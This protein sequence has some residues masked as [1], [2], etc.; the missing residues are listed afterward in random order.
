MSIRRPLVQVLSRNFLAV[1]VALFASALAWVYGGTRGEYLPTFV[2]WLTVFTAELMLC[3]P[4]QHEGETS[5]EARLRVWKRIKT[6][7]VVWCVLAFFAILVI[8]FVNVGLCPICDYPKILAGAKADP[9]A[10]FLPT[11]VNTV[12]HLNVALWFFAAL[13]MLLAVKHSLTKAGKRLTLEIIVWN[14]VLLALF[15]FLQQATEAEGPLWQ[16]FNNVIKGGDFFSTFGYPNMAGDYFTTLFA[17]AIGLW[18]EK[19]DPVVHE[20][21]QRRIKHKAV[22]ISRPF[23]KLNYHLLPAVLFY[24]AAMATLSRAAILLVSSLAI[25][26]FIHS[27][28]SLLAKRSKA[29]RFKYSI[30][31]MIALCLVVFIGYVFMPDDVRREVSTLD[32]VGVLDR[33]SGRGQYH[34]RVAFEVF[35]DFPVF[36][37]GGWGYKHHSIPKM[38]EEELRHLQQI[39]GINVHNDYLQFLAEHGAVGFILLITI[40]VMVLQPVVNVWVKYAKSF[41]FKVT[42]EQPPHPIIVFALPAGAFAGMMALVATLIHSFGDCPLRSP[43]VLSLFFI[44]LASIDGYMPTMQNPKE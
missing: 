1:F 40:V 21:T 14:G 5:N 23:W 3:F 20:E 41:R 22:K 25:I 11:C 44:V 26:F 16:P 15:G 6:D 2:P 18:R 39:G 36:G 13:T 35:K 12:E 43:A 4:Q 10:K 8:P 33:V 19:V 30:L 24:F 9:P 42:D 34:T 32:T 7:P 28:V 31:A 27:F 17:L 37:C 38:T 29:K